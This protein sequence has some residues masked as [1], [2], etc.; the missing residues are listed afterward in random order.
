MTFTSA[1]TARRRHI[2]LASASLLLAATLLPRIAFAQRATY[3]YLRGAD[4]LGTETLQISDTGAS[5]CWP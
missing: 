2:S 4:T 3:V 1:R 5:V